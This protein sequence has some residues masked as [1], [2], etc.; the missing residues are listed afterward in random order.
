MSSFDQSA[1]E[2]KLD[3]LRSKYG[4]KA[5]TNFTSSDKALFRAKQDQPQIVRIVPMPDGDIPMKE[6]KFYYN[7]G[8]TEKVGDRQ[9]GISILSPS[10]YGEPDPIEDYS[11][12][13]PEKNPSEK[14]TENLEQDAEIN[15]NILDKL[16][17][18]T[19]LFIP[20]IV[21]GQEAQGVKY[22]GVTE[23]LFGSIL[24]NI[25]KEGILIYDPVKGRDIKVW[26]QDMGTY[27]QTKFELG[28]TSPLST[29]EDASKQYINNHPVL[30]DQFSK[31][32]FSEIKQAINDILAPYT[33][34]PQTG[35]EHVAKPA[36][37]YT[38]VHKA[39][40]AAPAP[41]EAPIEAPIEEKVAQD[42]AFDDLP[43]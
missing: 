6:L 27:K 15:R 14:Y 35:E 26:L 33:G 37:D 13:N 18:T 28:N 24:D 42:D 9:Y 2:A 11:T 38:S 7:T 3:A 5:N 40:A 19:K 25:K 29:S 23:K 20:V 1:Q 10:S 43:F 8:L 39:A 30:T 4:N 16:R 36:T 12:S 34:Q 41:T 17:P 31:K 32:S 22:W 21:R